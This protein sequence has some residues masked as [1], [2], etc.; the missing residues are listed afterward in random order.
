MTNK[1]NLIAGIF[2]SLVIVTLMTFSLSYARYSDEFESE[3]SISGEMEYIVSN[4]I[5]VDSVNSFIAAIEN[6]YTNI[7]ISEEV[8]NPLIITGGVSDVNSDLIIDLNGH[9][10]QRN[11]RDP[12]LNVTDGVRLTIIDSSDTQTG[13]FYNPV[14]SVLRISGGTLTVEAGIFESGPR[15]GFTRG[16]GCRYASEYAVPFG[17][18]Y[19][20]DAGARLET[21]A[22]DVNYFLKNQDGN[23][24]TKYDN[25]KMPVIVPGVVNTT[26]GRTRINGNMYF[27]TSTLDQIL[28]DTYLYYTI[29]GASV[30]NTDMA[31]DDKSADFYYTY[32][33]R[34]ENG[35]YVYDGLTESSDTYLVTIYGYND[36]KGDASV[37]SGEQEFAAIQMNDGNLYVRGGRYTSYFGDGKTHCVNATGGYM[38][39]EEG[40]FEALGAGACVSINYAAGVNTQQD[41]LRVDSGN[42]YSE[43]GD[44]IHV[45]GGVMRVNGGTFDK[46][47][48]TTD[49]DEAGINNAAIHV[50]GGQLTLSGGTF[51]LTGNSLYGI[52]VDASGGT[53]SALAEEEM[54]TISNASFKFA[55]VGEYNYAIYSN[56]GKL[57]AT[58]VDFAFEGASTNN[59]GIFVEGADAAATVTGGSF[60]YQGGGSD[61][62]GIYSENGGVVTNG[63]AFTFGSAEGTEYCSNGRGIYV[64]GSTASATVTDGSFTFYNGGTGNRG[65]W[66]SQGSVVTKM[67]AASESMAFTFNGCSSSYGI[68]SEDGGSVE[69]SSPAFTF[70]GDGSNNTGI[71]SLGGSVTVANGN[72]DFNTGSG[73]GSEN[74]GIHSAGGSVTVNEGSFAFNST[75]GSK[76][77]GIYTTGSSNTEDKISVS[78]A[79]F[80]FDGGSYNYGIHSVPEDGLDSTI[81][82]KNISLTINGTYSA[83]ILAY[84][85]TTTIN[86]TF[87]CIVDRNDDSTSST[88]SSTAISTE[89]GTITFENGSIAT[90]TTDGLGIT[91]RATD[92]SNSVILLNGG[93]TLTSSHGT[94]I[95]MSGGTLAI[96]AKLDDGTYVK[97]DSVTNTISIT[98]TILE[99]GWVTPPKEDGTPDTSVSANTEIYNGIYIEGGSLLSYGTLN[100]THTGVAND[101]TWG[102]DLIYQ[103]QPIKSYAVRVTS[104]NANQSN[105][106]IYAGTISNKIGG[107][108]YAGGGTVTLGYGTNGPTVTTSGTE[109]HDTVHYNNTDNWRYYLTS[110][111]GH[112][113]EVNGGDLTVYGGSYSAQQGNGIFVRNLDSSSKSTVDIH[114]GTF[115]GYSIGQYNKRN[116]RILGPAAS[117]G[118]NVIGGGTVTIRNGT[119]GSMYQSSARD[120]NSGASVMGLSGQQAVVNIYGGNFYAYN[121]D[122]FSVFLNVTVNFGSQG[123]TG[124][125]NVN[126]TSAAI[127]SV[128]E[129]LGNGNAPEINIYYGAF[130]GINTTA[131]FGIYYGNGDA[132]LNIHGGTFYGIENA[133]RINAFPDSRI[134]LSAGTFINNGSDQAILNNTNR[135]LNYTNQNNG[136]RAHLLAD[137]ATAY[138]SDNINAQ[139]TNE[140]TG[141][142]NDNTNDFR[143]IDIV[144]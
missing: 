80:T 131:S 5:E 115:L 89:G 128:Q 83:G 27:E 15:D 121:C 132:T 39:V 35:S 42:F 17:S 144:S 110:T 126:S 14:G 125:I 105:V 32:Y 78:N 114:N 54:A 88:L 90:I 71:Y 30:D 72:F 101:D 143:R 134:Q 11:N 20:T 22:K 23:T 86:G 63:V 111:G 139:G 19:T 136:Y 65:I 94:A 122:A 97:D 76:N 123:Q 41:Y 112:A 51:S 109:M 103:Q 141:N 26:N 25:V 133:M 31:A 79:T 16:A 50:S 74:K 4:Q 120:T 99:N 49:V 70:A 73:Q 87:D 53:T 34:F 108:V 92:G 66:V 82:C 33:A 29:A 124:T 38:A 119:F 116:S 6:G 91:S 44:T 46:V 138:G 1:R 57:S 45:S 7:K 140:P 127:L 106:V 137:G 43:V 36:A 113:V 130:G 61:N 18:A 75:T 69:T 117:T 129:S 52:H 77:D 95:Y 55:G 59:R 12:L 96:G 10:L 37:Q 107:G 64:T 58:D 104:S 21:T 8:D 56:Y 68:Y 85:G 135:T 84:G 102:G 81:E 98:S 47:A 62:Y 2:L 100:V 13:C 28:G 24:Y 93:M 9:E 142:I 3:S 67:T 48:P 60:N 40:S 118:L